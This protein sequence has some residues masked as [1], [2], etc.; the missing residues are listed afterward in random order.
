MTSF[1]FF[2]NFSGFHAL[3]ILHIKREVNSLYENHVAIKI[4][5]CL[6]KRLSIEKRRM[7]TQWTD[8]FYW[9]E[10]INYA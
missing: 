1:R 8:Y 9:Y 7:C 5:Q 2:S 6:T 3:F 4:W 10:V